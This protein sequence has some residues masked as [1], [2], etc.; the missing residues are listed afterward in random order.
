[1]GIFMQ[2]FSGSLLGAFLLIGGTEAGLC[3]HLF[4]TPKEA[5]QALVDAARQPQE[6][7]L[8]E[9]MGAGAKELL[10]SGDEEI[11]H[12][13][14]ADFLALADQAQG[15]VE[16]KPGMAILVFGA[17]PWSF[18]IPLRQKDGKWAFDLKAGKQE[19]RDRAVGRNELT[20][21]AACA[22]YVQAQR[23]YY[24]SL[25]DDEPVQQYARRFISSPGRHD[26]LW[27]QPETPRD[28]SPLGDVIAAAA[29]EKSSGKQG[30]TPYFGYIYRILTKQG[31]D[32][33]GGAYGYVVGGRMLA[34]FALLAYPERWGETGVMTFLCDQQGKVYQRNLGPG[35]ATEAARIESLNPGKGWEAVR[36]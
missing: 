8:D 11:D 30:P 24:D 13:R 17:D 21:I 10:S 25:H 14:L 5:S 32:A 19:I 3:Q 27:W 34:G 28:R 6:G 15:V 20:A 36:E 18:P 12:Q 26:G 35:T 33:P 22:D 1:M 16:E 31:P 29:V 7:K 23:E 4:D 9:M 2:A